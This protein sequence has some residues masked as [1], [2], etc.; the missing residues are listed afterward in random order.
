MFKRR[1]RGTEPNVRVHPRTRN[2]IRRLAALTGRPTAD[3]YAEA[4]DQLEAKQNLDS[5][6]EAFAQI[7]QNPAVFAQEMAKRRGKKR[8]SRL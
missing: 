4:V 1:D 2:Q 7:G 5:S 6:D 3:L 8:R